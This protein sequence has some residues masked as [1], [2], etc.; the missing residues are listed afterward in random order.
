MTSYVQVSLGAV[1]DYRKSYNGK[2]CAYEIRYDGAT[3]LNSTI[4]FFAEILGTKKCSSNIYHNTVE[5]IYY[6]LWV[7]HSNENM[8][9]RKGL[10]V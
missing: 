2:I 5:Q 10:L 6:L 8:L 4:A 7:S 9:I 1:T 3:E